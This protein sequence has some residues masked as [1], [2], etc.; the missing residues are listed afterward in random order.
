[1]LSFEIE[2]GNNF[3]NELET[4][5]NENKIRYAVILSTEEFMDYINDYFT[6]V[7]KIIEIPKPYEDKAELDGLDVIQYDLTKEEAINKIYNT[8]YF[9]FGIYILK[10]RVYGSHYIK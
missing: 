8:Y 7:S 10:E 9:H 6:P 5:N 2:K 1:M 3:S 4:K